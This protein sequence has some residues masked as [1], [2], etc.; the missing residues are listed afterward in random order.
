MEKLIK[1][2][3]KC[4]SEKLL[5]D[6]GFH[7]NRPGGYQVWCRE[8]KKKSSAKRYINNKEKIKKCTRDW[9]ANNK[10]RSKKN[11]RTWRIKNKERVR[12]LRRRNSKNTHRTLRG[13]LNNNMRAVIGKCLKGNK[14]GC[15]WGT[16]TGYTVEELKKHI[17]KKFLPGMSWENRNLWH[18]DHKIPISAFNFEK[19]EHLDFKKCWDLKNLRPMWAKDNMK[20]HNK[21]NQAFQPSLRLTLR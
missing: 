13:K 1:K 3:K 14:N 12:E 8:C 10:I 21:L 17:E 20:K 4:G 2:C 7:K 16:L 9:Y 18:I 5:K 6:F 19:P 15:H 11:I